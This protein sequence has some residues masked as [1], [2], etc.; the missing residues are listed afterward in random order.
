MAKTLLDLLNQEQKA[1]L[2]HRGKTL[3]LAS[4]AQVFEK[5]ES[6]QQIFLVRKG[7]I[8]L[9]RLTRNG[10]EK[11]FKVFW[12]GGLIA[13]MAIFMQ[14]RVYP[15]SAKADQLTQLTAISRA[16]IVELLQSS[17]ELYML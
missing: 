7:K 6:A 17:P 9:Y 12:A 5:G 13:E 10:E 11:V 2:L 8:T 3:Q 14:P 15:M 1:A 16:S 4:G